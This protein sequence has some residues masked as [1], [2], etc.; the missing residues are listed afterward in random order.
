MTTAAQFYQEN[1]GLIHT[2][3]RKG[4]TRLLR[5]GVALDYEDV[6]QEM[7]ITFLKAHK[8]FDPA[9][10]FQ[11][12]TYFFMAAYNRLNSW[13]QKMI[14]ERLEHG[15]VSIQELGTRPDGEET[16]MEE[17]VMVD[18]ST[19]DSYCRVTQFLEHIAQTLSPLATLILAWV[20]TPPQEIISEVRKAEAYAHYGRQRGHNVRCM[21]DITPRYVANFIR[22]ISDVSQ[23]EADRALREIERLRRS[24]AK[25]YLGA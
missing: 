23:I 16:N 25:Q 7:A 6:F 15:V 12:S 10:G 5:A 19:P 17:V 1:I 14:E 24:D 11:F 8:M 20:V 13:A 22:M 3:A 21:V 2:V 9:K 18:E 4:H